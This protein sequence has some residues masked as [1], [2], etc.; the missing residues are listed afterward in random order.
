MTSPSAA[1]IQRECRRLSRDTETLANLIASMERRAE[2][3]VAAEGGQ[4]KY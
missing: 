1:P 2:A 4:T 3:V